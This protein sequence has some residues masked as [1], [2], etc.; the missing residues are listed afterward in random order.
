MLGSA[1]AISLAFLTVV[2]FFFVRKL[3]KSGFQS[4]PKDA[5]LKG[6]LESLDF[7]IRYSLPSLSSNIENALVG[8]LFLSIT[9]TTNPPNSTLTTPVKFLLAK[10]LAFIATSFASAAKLFTRSG[11]TIPSSANSISSILSTEITLGLEAP[12]LEALTGLDGGGVGVGASVSSGASDAGAVTS[13]VSVAS[14]LTGLV[15]PSNGSSSG[16]GGAEMGSPGTSSPD[17]LGSAVTWRTSAGCDAEGLETRSS[18]TS[19]SS[20]VS[21][22]SPANGSSRLE[23]I[24]TKRCSGAS[25]D[26]ET[27]SGVSGTSA[28]CHATSVKS[29]AS[30]GSGVGSVSS[31]SS[32]NDSSGTESV[33]ISTPEIS[34]DIL[35][36]TVTW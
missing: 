17:I 32:S 15:S 26:G 7:V 33:E 20:G 35:G 31:T 36:S 14:C 25:L 3:S 1:L 16:T 10:Y 9:S 4:L 6:C 27:N 22:S 19:V 11:G 24:E 30:G 13:G 8:T 12:P 34:S 5:K 28:G 21:G 23:A 2:G 29:G 18:G